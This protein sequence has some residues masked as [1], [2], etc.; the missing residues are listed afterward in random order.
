MAGASLIKIDVT[1]NSPYFVSI[2]D[3]VAVL[4]ADIE[5]RETPDPERVKRARRLMI[6]AK[7]GKGEKRL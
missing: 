5:A 4:L 3:S 7:I 1:G 6:D 2:P